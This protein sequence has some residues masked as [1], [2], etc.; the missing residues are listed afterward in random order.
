MFNKFT[1]K[2]AKEKLSSAFKRATLGLALATTLSSNNPPAPA[3]SAHLSPGEIA[4]VQSIFGN[5]VNTSIVIKNF[6]PHHLE[7]FSEPDHILMETRASVND[8]KNII[9][10]GPEY[11]SDDYSQEDL[12]LYGTFLHEMTHIWQRQKVSGVTLLLMSCHDYNYALNDQSRF[13]DFCI[14]QQGAIMEN[15]VQRFLHHSHLSLGIKNTPENDALLKKVV[16][17]Q[18]PEARK[19][20]LALEAQQQQKIAAAKTNAPKI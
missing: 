17:D 7:Y 14:E 2:G 11:S 9:F 6:S 12:M 13:S 3:P 20:R 15:Y 16:E 1:F 8:K 4:L 10:Y 19:T 5:E 18:F